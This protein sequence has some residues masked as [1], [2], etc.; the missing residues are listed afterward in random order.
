VLA[1]DELGEFLTELSN[2]DAEQRVI[3]LRVLARNPGGD[4]RLLP[5]LRELLAD[6]TVTVLWIPFEYGEVRWMAAEA[7]AAEYRAAG[8]DEPV[9]LDDA[10]YPLD[11]GSINALANK[12]GVDLK[13]VPGAAHRFAALRDRGLLPVRKV[14]F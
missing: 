13:G 2:D 5:Q 12:A 3:A 7:L 10:P 14:P 6:R 11:S 9:V 8:I 4:P 1:D